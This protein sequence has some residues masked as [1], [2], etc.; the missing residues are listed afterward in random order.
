MWLTNSCFA[1]LH[2]GVRGWEQIAF[3]PVA[4]AQIYRGDYADQCQAS[5]S[6]LLQTTQSILILCS[7]YEPE[8]LCK[9]KAVILMTIDAV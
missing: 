5:V 2:H 7:R 1:G 6:L 8:L 3:C 4:P 9:S